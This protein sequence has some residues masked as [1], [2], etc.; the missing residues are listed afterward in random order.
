[1]RSST[2][3][4]VPRR[5]A[6]WVMRPNQ[7]STDSATVLVER[8]PCKIA[9]FSRLFEPEGC[10]RSILKSF[11]CG[12]A[13]SARSGLEPA[14]R[15]RGVRR[16]EDANLYAAACSSGSKRQSQQGACLVKVEPRS[17]RHQ[18]CRGAVADVAEKIRFHMPFREKLL[19]ARLTFASRKELLI[20]FCVIK[21]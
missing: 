9:R 12:Q 18:R 10:F 3:V 7:R 11:S 6:R 4:N 14:E 2:L 16:L 17:P 5:M 15:S 1:M 20:E 13:P 19:L 8:L 21:A